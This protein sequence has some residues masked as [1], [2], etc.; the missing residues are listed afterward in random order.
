MS[1][2]DYLD[3]DMA[4]YFGHESTTSAPIAVP[5]I[6]R[7]PIHG[8]SL[9]DANSDN[10]LEAELDLQQAGGMA[11]GATLVLV[12]LP[13]GTDGSFL[14]GYLTLVENNNV[15]IV[16]TSF[17]GPEATY[18]AAY[19]GGIDQ[20]GVLQAFN[21]IFKQGNAQG[22]SFVASSGDFGGLGLP[23]VSYFTSPPHTPPVVVGNML[24]GV[25]F[26]ASSPYV[27]AVG[28]T[29]LQTTYNP[30]SLESNYVS[31]NAYGDPLVPF[32]PYGTGN[33]VAGGYW[34]SGGG[35]SII[36]AKPPYQYFVE[37][38]SETR[39]L[40]DV[41]LQMGGCP[42][43]ISQRPCHSGDSYSY[44]IFAGKRIGL[45]GTSIS[46]PDFA[47]ILA[48]EEQFLGGTRLG[49][50]NYEIYAIAAAQPN[51]SG[52]PLDLL[53]QGQPGFNG[54]FYTT[55]TGYNFVLGVGT[56]LVRNFIFASQVSPAGDP[57]T[58]SNP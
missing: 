7:F 1:V 3:S 29:N 30:P 20:T 33:L 37:T 34:G 12:N 55:K 51:V 31:E 32:D 17:G 14:D 4:A 2:S 5:K 41:S 56:P 8:G 19:N 53:H 52:S 22:I 58:P 43:D 48:L 50:V 25:E 45:I 6:I 16:S 39:A 26:F 9:F 11:P 46:A 36:F 44:A 57:Q 24:P 42:A 49:N 27:T 18:T 23:P 35:K 54:A 13:D 38:D 10:S 28:G 15:D 40:P 47:G 21:D